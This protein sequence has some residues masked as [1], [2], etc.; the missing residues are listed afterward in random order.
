MSNGPRFDRDGGTIPDRLASVEDYLARKEEY[1]RERQ[2]AVDR[3]IADLSSRVGNLESWKVEVL[4]FIGATKVRWG[5][6]SFV[7][8]ILAAVLTAGAVK[9]LHL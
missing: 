7:T 1:D 8:A 4:V 6:V 2:A 9:V 3:G 5:A